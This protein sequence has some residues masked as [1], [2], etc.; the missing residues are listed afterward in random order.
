[1]HNDP[2][3]GLL[4]WPRREEV[5]DVERFDLLLDFTNL[6]EKFVGTDTH[7]QE[8]WALVEQGQPLRARI[9]TLL[10]TS[11][12]AAL[13]KSVPKTEGPTLDPLANGLC[14]IVNEFSGHACPHRGQGRLVSTDKLK[15]GRKYNVCPRCGSHFFGQ[16]FSRALGVAK[17]APLLG[18]VD[19]IEN[20][21]STSVLEG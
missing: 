1:M 17:H 16:G 14:D 8:F 7:W 20:A 9:A 10:D 21:V 12:V 4:S 2:R 18:N 11:K 19:V 6:D 13:A 3:E 15:K 5:P